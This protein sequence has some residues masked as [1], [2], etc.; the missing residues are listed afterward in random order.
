MDLKG[1]GVGTRNWVDSGQNRD[2]W[3]A[4][5]NG[6]LNVRAPNFMELFG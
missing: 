6:A 4:L 1:I 3:G 5:V 2:C